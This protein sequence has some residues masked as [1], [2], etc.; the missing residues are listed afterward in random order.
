LHAPIAKVLQFEKVKVEEIKEVPKELPK[1]V[2]R[3]KPPVVKEPPSPKE[4]TP[5]VPA[6]KPTQRHS[7]GDHGNIPPE[8]AEKPTVA[9]KPRFPVAAPR[10]IMSDSPAE[11]KAPEERPK[12]VVPERP[13]IPERPASLKESFKARSSDNLDEAT[14]KLL[15]PSSPLYLGEVI[16]EKILD[17]LLILNNL[18]EV[19]TL[20]LYLR[21]KKRVTTFLLLNQLTTSSSNLT[22]QV[23]TF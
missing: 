18:Q 2:L 1:E 4:S 15:E 17:Q 12:P 21:T 23:S 9:Q 7:G 10:T 19:P 5:P 11:K 13:V 6:P 16:I 14:P 8:V 22:E 20:S 3:E